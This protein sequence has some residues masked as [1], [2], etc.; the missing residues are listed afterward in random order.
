MVNR[1]GNPIDVVTADGSGHIT[2]INKV[3]NNYLFEI[4]KWGGGTGNNSPIVSDIPD[5]TRLQGI[6]FTQI[7]L[8]SYV[9]DLEDPDEDINWTYV[10][11]TNL[12]V[13][14]NPYMGLGRNN[15]QSSQ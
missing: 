10:G 11:N 2:F 9:F 12:S 7:E 8:D 15:D 1:T 14:I 5:Q 4:F 3:W 6:S 13:S